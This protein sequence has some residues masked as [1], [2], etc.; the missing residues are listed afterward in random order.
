MILPTGVV[1]AA[2]GKTLVNSL[3]MKMVPIEPGQFLMGSEDGDW[4]ERPVHAVTISRPFHM[5]ATEVTN[6]QFEQFDPDHRRLRGK[7]GFSKADDEAVVFVSWHEA[8]AFCKWLSEKE[9]KP[10]RLPT[11]AEWEYACRAGTTAAYHA[12]DTLPK[13]F[14]KNVRNSWFPAPTRS[15]DGEVV[16][17][18]VAKTSSSDWG[19]HDMHGNVEEWCAD[20]YGPYAAG[21]QTDPV[22]YQMGDFR[23][24]RGGSHST[25]LSFLRS[26]NRSGMLPDDKTWLVGLRVVMG[27]MPTTK[28][29]PAP[30]KPLNQQNVSQQVLAD[31]AT[32]PDP[33]KPYFEGP[34][35]YVKISTGSNGPLFSRHNHDPAIVE[36][37]NG[38]LLAIWYTCLTEP[39]RE[40]GIAASRLRY[41]ADQWDPASPF[42]DAPDRND[43]APAMW[44]DGKGAFF[45]FNGLSVAG[46]W[47]SLATILRVSHDSG[48][49][50]STAQLINPEHGLRHMPV[51]S[52]FQTREGW[53]VLPCDAVPGGGGGTAIHISKDDGRNWQDPS[54]DTGRPSFVSGGRGGSIAGIH[55]GVLQLKDGRLMALGRGDNIDGHMPMSISTD[56]G[57]TWTYSASE[58]PPIGGNQRLVL[59]RLREGPLLFV[60]FTHDFFR[61][62]R[63]PDK[64][65]P[66]FVTDAAGGKRQIYGMFAAL[67]FDEGET[68]PIKKPITPGGP[69]R[70]LTGVTLSGS[71][72][73]DDTHAEP[74][75][76]LSACQTPDGVIQLISSGLHYAFNLTWIKTPIPASAL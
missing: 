32:G 37:P 63:N 62:R 50:W 34:R 2:D 43:H 14:H 53:I 58:F 57:S 11:E 72:L 28:P 38:D 7:L 61:Y 30:A 19:L 73:L 51:E 10:Y 60:S 4:D 12:G 35:P 25:L 47:G 1:L 46:T 31:P 40:L 39:G 66:F 74:R 52:V 36:C 71:F 56:M 45:H 6:G 23:V 16:S 49:T 15:K 33:T 76:Y 65:P 5:S 42:W 67:S 22:G 29:L 75:G 69:P 27:E 44:A 70:Q 18:T 41:G 20:W 17:L 54:S 9:G 21:D 13:A 55:G 3:G 8:V 59:I 48:A 68:W 26:P 24:T 64:T